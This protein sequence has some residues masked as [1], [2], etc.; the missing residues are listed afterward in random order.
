MAKFTLRP[1]RTSD[2]D[3]LVA[4]DALCFSEALG[5][6]FS[7][8]SDYL[9]VNKDL[10]LEEIQNQEIGKSVTHVCVDNSN[11][12]I[13][14]FCVWHEKKPENG[15]E[16]TAEEKDTWGIYFFLYVLN[17]YQVLSYIQNNLA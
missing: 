14:A 7:K 11:G 9:E 5:E 17:C 12:N 15:I 6:D 3:Q 4:L 10:I 8:R 2:I 1:A 16:L 13:V